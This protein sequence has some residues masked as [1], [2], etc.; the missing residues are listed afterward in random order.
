MPGEGDQKVK[1]K[2]SRARKD[3]NEWERKWLVNI[4]DDRKGVEETSSIYMDF[5]DRITGQ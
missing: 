3:P 4:I 2:R 1:K 5:L